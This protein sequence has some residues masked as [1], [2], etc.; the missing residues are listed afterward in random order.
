MQELKTKWQRWESVWLIVLY[1][2][3]QGIWLSKRTNST[4]DDKDGKMFVFMQTAW[5]CSNSCLPTS[6]SKHF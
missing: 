4:S 3:L 5:L 2:W 1:T 6:F